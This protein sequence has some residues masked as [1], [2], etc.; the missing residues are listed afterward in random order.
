LAR[1]FLSF[2]STLVGAAMCVA[3]SCG[4]YTGR[5]P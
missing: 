5:W 3:F 1:V 4:L 2:C